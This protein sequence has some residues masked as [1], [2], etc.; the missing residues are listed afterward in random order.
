[1]GDKDWE[2][3]RLYYSGGTKFGDRGSNHYDCL[4]PIK[5]KTAA[6]IAQARG[7]GGQEKFDMMSRVEWGQ[8]GCQEILDLMSSVG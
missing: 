2:Q 6:G 1:M 8:R 4:Y 3:C 5:T 7:R